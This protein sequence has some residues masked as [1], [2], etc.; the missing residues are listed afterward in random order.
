MLQAKPF[1]FFRSVA[2]SKTG[3]LI[4]C[5]LSSKDS[6]RP[7]AHRYG[8]LASVTL[9]LLD[10]DGERSPSHLLGKGHHLYCD[11]LYASGLFP[12]PSFDPF[13]LEISFFP[14]SGALSPAPAQG[15][16]LHGH[17]PEDHGL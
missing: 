15:D 2:C 6:Q 14:V 5:L 3:F 8:S 12:L 9:A 16:F 1:P 4:N 7:Y 13:T 17:V 10:G 11:N